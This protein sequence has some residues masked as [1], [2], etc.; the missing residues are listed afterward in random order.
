MLL[1]RLW[2][3]SFSCR[4]CKGKIVFKNLIVQ[5]Y[6]LAAK[7]NY[8]AAQYMIGAFYYSGYASFEQDIDKAVKYYQKAA[9]QGNADAL[10]KLGDCY[11]QGEGIERNLIKAFDCYRLAAEEGNSEAQ[12]NLGNCYY[13]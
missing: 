6:S 7:Q 11:S 4:S 5:W 13:E 8:A 3:R 10:V 1:L 2:S 12:N 9:M